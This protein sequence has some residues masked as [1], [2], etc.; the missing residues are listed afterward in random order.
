MEPERPN[1]DGRSLPFR[2]LV[3]LLLQPLQDYSRRSAIKGR[4]GV[5]APTQL[6]QAAIE[7]FIARWRTEV[8]ND[9]FPLFRLRMD[10]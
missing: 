9:I 5:L 2:D 8:G 1:N 3:Q 10:F 6:K 4:P 7:K